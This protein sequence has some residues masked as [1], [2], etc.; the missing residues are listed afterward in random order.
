VA[1]A[2][3]EATREDRAW[4]VLT[5]DVRWPFPTSQ[6]LKVRA[7]PASL[8]G[9]TK[10]QLF[11]LL[12]PSILAALRPDYNWEVSPNRSD[13]NGSDF[14]GVH[15]FLEDETLGISAAITIG[16][17]C[18]I[19]SGRVR[20]VVH[21]VAGSITDML[22]TADP[23][24]IV[25]ALSAS[26][27]RSRIDAARQRLE[28]VVGRQC[29]I[30]DRRQIEG[31]M[32]AHWH[33]VEDVL[34]PALTQDEL[35]DMLVYLDSRLRERTAVETHAPRRV[36]GGVPFRISVALIA[37]GAANVELRLR[38]LGPPDAEGP[39]LV[40]PAAAE[41]DAGASFTSSVDDP[42]RAGCV[43]EMVTYAIG[44]VD[45]GDVVVQTAT[46]RELARV[47]L[48]EIRVVENVRPRF[49]PTPFERPIRTLREA[50]VRART[51]FE[52]ITIIGRGGSGKSRLIEEMML[53][54]VRD[55]W[56]AVVAAQSKFP[57]D[58]R[59]ILG[60]LL[61]RLAVEPGVAATPRSVIDAVGRFDTAL[62]ARAAPTI[63]TLIGGRNGRGE[64]IEQDLIS[65]LVLLTTARSRNTPLVIHLQDLHC[66]SA[67]VL[68]LLQRFAWQVREVAASLYDHAG[69]LVLFEGRTGE[70]FGSTASK[71]ASAPF[72]SFVAQQAAPISCASLSPEH[73][74]EFVQRLF[75]TRR[76]AH[77]V[78]PDHLYQAQA[79]LV[80]RVVETAGSNPFHTLAQVQLLKERGILSQNTRT[81]LLYLVR[82]EPP[83]MGLPDSVF[84]SIRLRWEHLRRRRPEIALLLWGIALV[85]DRISM[86]HL[87]HLWRE[88]A[89]QVSSADIDATDMLWLGDSDAPDAV[90]RH[91]N[92]VRSIRRFEMSASDRARVVDAHDS[93]FSTQR[94]M[95]APDQ[96][97][98][99]RVLL[100][101]PTPDTARARRLLARARDAA[102]RRG[103]DSVRRRATSLLLDARWRDVDASIASPAVFLRCCDEDL[104]LVRELLAVDLAA[105]RRRLELIDGRL[106]AQVRHRRSGS[107]ETLERRRIAVQVAHGQL[108]FNSGRPRTSADMLHDALERLGTRGRGTASDDPWAVLRAELLHALASAEAL[109]GNVDAA[110]Q[111]SEEAVALVQHWTTPSAHDIIG[112]YANIL[113]AR[114]P[115]ASER[116]LR[117]RL[118]AR[119][120]SEPP[121]TDLSEVHLSMALILQA[122]RLPDADQQRG[123]MLSEARERLTTVA[124][125]SGHL[126][127]HPDAAA[128]ALMLGIV[129]ELEG[130]S[131]AVSW[132]AQAA[133][134]ASQGRQLEILWRARINLALALFD[135]EHRV[136]PQVRDQAA[137]ALDLMVETLESEV[138]GNSAPRLALMSVP[139]AHAIRLLLLAEDERAAHALV[140]YPA[141][142]A[143][144][145]DLETATLYEDRGGRA[146]HEWLRVRDA[147]YVIY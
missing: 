69:V 28:R 12:V 45:L 100:E 86:T 140:R 143:C 99:A 30:L 108:L 6:R 144:F 34:R 27:D 96:I 126:G 16:G 130:E 20:N 4:Q 118:T 33:V 111:I 70:D 115:V 105:A 50:A 8:T 37:P 135:L 119:S 84:E 98:W 24:V 75:E 88:L 136:T 109:S 107:H 52:N 134:S 113:L 41:A 80:R 68:E 32:G 110:L 78:L 18:K 83:D 145:V 124:R 120:H 132:F 23:T 131:D 85:D 35:A 15:H 81:G 147:D 67:E 43:L 89:P 59:G 92:Y 127:H 61:V 95:G 17:Q 48:G 29:H 39:V 71:D 54:F 42:L 97:R 74:R 101:H 64:V 22:A 116:I 1:G 66:C 47:S 112:T 106:Q 102:G 40:A 103:D 117:R 26:L 87:R 123:A 3:D 72:E 10:F 49:Y 141:L 25:V 2:V 60:D 128:A 56:A 77:R 146:S 62:S 36:L 82:P 142:R 94:R 73:G 58:V 91:E 65:V 31:L 19:R 104:V 53:E 138:D 21:L 57:D 38:W 7:D 9:R 122:H 90:F 133:A 14:W 5:R 76:S 13:D 55:G 93:W 137:G 114:D 121:G 125:V 79:Q 129:S 11:E 51:G 46:H 139:I 44:D 63:E